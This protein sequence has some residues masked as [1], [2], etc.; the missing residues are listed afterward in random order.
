MGGLAC[1]EEQDFLGGI[2]TQPIGQGRTSGTC[3]DDDVVV[4][5]SFIHDTRLFTLFPSPKVIQY[6]QSLEK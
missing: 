2:F 5:R 4:L 1:F 6:G 3:P